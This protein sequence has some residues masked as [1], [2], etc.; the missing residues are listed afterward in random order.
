MN[1]QELSEEAYLQTESC[2]NTSNLTKAPIIEVD[3]SRYQPI[4]DVDLSRYQPNDCVVVQEISNNYVAGTD[5][6]KP[7]D[8]LP[9][10][11]LVV[12]LIS[13]VYTWHNNKR[14]RT[15]SVEDDYWLRTVVF[16]SILNPLI[17]IG[18]E[19]PEYFRTSNDLPD[20]FDGYFLDKMNELRDKTMVLKI[21]SEEL[22]SRV[23]SLMDDLDDNISN[24]LTMADYCKV[25]GEFS[26]K[27]SL[28]LKDAQSKT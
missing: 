18:S 25:F 7:F 5:V 4:I 15:I 19:S 2:S 6:S 20:F 8:A 26:N 9:W 28:L 1:V 24:V 13:I 11:A 10:L 27:L 21:V 16:P 23:N 22:Y 3:L 14:Q 17:E 12:S